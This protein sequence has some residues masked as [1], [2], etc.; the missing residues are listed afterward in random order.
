[1]HQLL[2]QKA[3]VSYALNLTQHSDTTQNYSLTGTCQ[4]ASGCGVTVTQN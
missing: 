4:N 3:L 2:S 1:M